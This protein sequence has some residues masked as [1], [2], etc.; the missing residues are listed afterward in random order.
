MVT[1]T[2]ISEC[3]RLNKDILNKQDLA[4][5]NI[6]VNMNYVRNEISVLKTDFNKKNCDKVLIEAKLGYVTDVTSK[7]SELDKIRIET[8]SYKQR[9]YRL[10]LGVVILV[11]GLLIVATISR[12]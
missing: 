7:Y 2:Q 10:I 3:Q 4:I 12:D 5:A 1:S 9:N 11:S 8:D 6:G